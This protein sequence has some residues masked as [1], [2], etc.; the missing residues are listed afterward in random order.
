MSCSKSWRRSSVRSSSKIRSQGIADERM[1]S[2]TS[3]ST[4]RR[5]LGSIGPRT[6]RSTSE[7]ERKSPFAKEPITVMSIPSLSASR[8]IRATAADA[9]SCP[10]LPSL[11]RK[12]VHP[13]HAGLQSPTTTL[14]QDEE[15]RKSAISLM[16]ALSDRFDRRP[17]LLISRGRIRMS[18]A[19][20]P[21]RGRT[22]MFAIVLLWFAQIQAI[23]RQSP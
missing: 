2:A 11:R 5:R 18:V 6:R 8:R 1:P 13:V 10:G 21:S 4:R 23:I 7:W 9:R 16:G 19:L 22:V 3:R 15:S 12:C 14:Q 17:V 20:R